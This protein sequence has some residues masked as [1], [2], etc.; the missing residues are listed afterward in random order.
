MVSNEASIV[1]QLDRGTI[2]FR[3]YPE[4]K[5]SCAQFVVVL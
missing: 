4:E 5:G 1:G 3:P 2:E